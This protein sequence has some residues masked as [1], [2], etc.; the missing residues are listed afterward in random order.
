[1]SELL[2]FTQIVAWG[3]LLL[4]AVLIVI[5]AVGQMLEHPA[6]RLADDIMGHHWP[7]LRTPAFHVFLSAAWL[8]ATW[9]LEL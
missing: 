7:S 1:M 9:A 3:A 8:Y 6:K 2:L 5:V 4:N